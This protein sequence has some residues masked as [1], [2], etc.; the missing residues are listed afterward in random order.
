M[1]PEPDFMFIDAGDPLGDDPRHALPYLG[2]NWY[3]WENA[4]LILSDGYPKMG[5]VTID[6]VVRTFRQRPTRPTTH[7]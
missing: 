3:W 6:H 2:P 5:K 7:W 4:Q 1:D